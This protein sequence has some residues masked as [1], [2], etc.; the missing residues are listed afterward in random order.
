MRFYNY[1]ILIASLIYVYGLCEAEPLIW[2]STLKSIKTTNVGTNESQTIVDNMQWI[3]SICLYGDH[4]YWTEMD[5]IMRA[6]RNGSNIQV[7][8]TIFHF[9]RSETLLTI[10]FYSYRRH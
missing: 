10:L 3:T 9:L 5:R 6:N 2:F 4:V 7:I 1:C 8:A